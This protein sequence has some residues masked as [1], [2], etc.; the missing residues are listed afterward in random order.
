MH[1]RRS[2]IAII[3]LAIVTILAA[4]A[5][6]ADPSARLA[7]LTPADDVL[8]RS[9]EMYGA[10]RSYADTGVV[11]REYGT[12]SQDRDT[13]TTA[14][15]REPRGFLLEFRK[16]AGDRYVVWGDPNAFHTWWKATGQRTDYP[17]PNNLPA[18][19]GSGV[20][21]SGVALKIPSLLY[22]K[23]PL[24]SA[25]TNFTDATVQGVDDIAGHRCHRLVGTAKDV[26]GTGREVNV[27]AM[28]VWI[29]A[30]TQ[31]IRKIVEEW[32][33]LPGQRNRVTTTF[34]P[35]V[36][37]G[38]DDSRLRFT[39]PGD[40]AGAQP[41]AAPPAA[42]Q[43]PAATVPAAAKPAAA[44]TITL[45]PGLTIVTAINQPQGDYES[46]KRIESI[47]PAGIRVRYSS[48]RQ[49]P[50]FEYTGG[51]RDPPWI[52]FVVHR[53]IRHEDLAASASY[54]Q[55]FDP[56]GVPEIV[57]GTTA[58]G[59]SGQ[60][61][62]DLRQ[63][64]K[65]SLSIFQGGGQLGV[66]IDDTGRSKG[67]GEY[68]LPGE[69]TRV[70]PVPQM[71]KV[72]VDGRITELPALRARG[73]FLWDDSEFFFLLDEANPLTLGFR[74]GI[75]KPPEPQQAR[76][77]LQVLRIERGC[78]DPTLPSSAKGGSGTAAAAGG[79]AG[80][81]GSG[82]AAA[83]SA[84]AGRIEHDLATTGK[85]EIYSIYFAFN[86]DAIREESEPTLREIAA[87]LQRHPEWRLSI[88]GH[89]DNI[90]GDAYNLQLSNRRAAA[91]KT[92]LVSGKGIATARLTTTGHG[93]SRPK[94]TNETLEGR[95][96]NRRVELVRQP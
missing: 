50:G 84:A 59:I 1:T 6:V 36:N 83:P 34:E 86:S 55:I 53:T 43:A 29:D 38:L 33:P 44:A 73:Q 80:P 74:I 81:P 25:F 87:V 12:S 70:D 64:G 21:T 45:C 5:A 60:S 18:L 24:V 90:A 77:N 32:K 10:L 78:E 51:P 13:F 31:V 39:P 93:E 49:Q 7:A 2:S 92:A 63:K 27:R 69:L 28:T 58:L 14:F 22:A 26:Y 42:Q 46:I 72:M 62:R 95:A 88:E 35:Q 52:P 8:Q 96:G 23:A 68:R 71:V 17:N 89:T 67:M 19:D 65:T 37:P 40:A 66:Q 75:P 76:D 79:G 30:A 48:Y 20:Q 82:A 61:L 85:A 57:K 9:R 54:M 11:L 47:T 94:A 3:R 91:V 15:R 41:V 4:A 16:Q 56:E